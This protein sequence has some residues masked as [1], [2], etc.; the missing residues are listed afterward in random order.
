MKI[1]KR[2]IITIGS[3]MTITFLADTIQYSIAKSPKGKF[4]Y[5]FPP[6][7]DCMKVL[8]VGIL[9]GIIINAV[10]DAVENVQKSEEEKKLDAL[11]ESELS[12]IR[13]GNIPGKE[14]VKIIWAP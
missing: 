9:A 12:K 2:A 3:A 7:L 4:K 11:I 5:S 1:D 13:E 6:F 10:V 14:P 8:G